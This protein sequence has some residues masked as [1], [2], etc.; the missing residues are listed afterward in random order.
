MGIAAEWIHK[1][2]NFETFF[3]RL[4]NQR[5]GKEGSLLHQ[6][7]NN[8]QEEIHFFEQNQY[9]FIKQFL[10]KKTWLETIKND[11]KKCNV[12]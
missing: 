3:W 12:T 9:L 7:L 2:K 5:K 10:M 8:T 4:M 1:I 11:L 6:S